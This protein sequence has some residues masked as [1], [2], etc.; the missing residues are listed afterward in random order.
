MQTHFLHVLVA[1][2][3]IDAIYAFYPESFCD[4]NLAIRKVF[5]FSDSAFMT[6][7][8]LFCC[9]ISFFSFCDKL[10]LFLWQNFSCSN[11]WFFSDP[12]NSF[13]H[14]GNY[15]WFL[16]KWTLKFFSFFSLSTKSSKSG[17]KIH[18]RDGARFFCDKSVTNVLP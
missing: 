15:L 5:A 1:N 7:L 14:L 8:F 10:F 16:I 18:S 4:N 12:R 6:H 2:L 11:F 3:K 9:Q 13:S 17:H